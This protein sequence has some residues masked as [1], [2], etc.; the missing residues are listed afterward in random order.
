L[1]NGKPPRYSEEFKNE[2][3]RL[4]R[5]GGQPVSVVAYDLGMSERQLRRWIRG[6]FID[7]SPRL[8]LTAAERAELKQLRKRVKILQQEQE[9]LRKAADFFARETR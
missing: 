4:V 3:V 1:V 9:I 5:T 2:A 8:G 7:P 6:Q